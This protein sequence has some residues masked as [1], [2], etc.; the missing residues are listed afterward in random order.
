MKYVSFEM[1]ASSSFGVLQGDRVVAVASPFQ[2]L[3]EELAGTRGYPLSMVRLRAPLPQPGKI[4]CM[5][6]NYVEHA[7]EQGVEPPKSP[8]IFAKYPTA[9]I[10][11]G[12]P[13]VL[14]S[15][16]QKVDY[17]AE[18]AVVIG[19]RGKKIAESHALDHVL[20]YTI[21]N[22][23]S[24]RD[25]QFTDGQ[26]VR[27]KSCDTFAPLG[28]WIVGK[29]EIPDPHRLDIELRVNGDLRQA[30]NTR[31]QIFKIPFL[32]SYLSQA[33]TLE[34]GDILSTGTPS[35]VGVF[36]DPP[37]FLKPGDVVEITIEAIGTLQNPVV[38]EER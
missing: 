4:M 8:V 31:H 12:D 3:E 1:N 23:V 36:R 19:R 30:S 29:E 16:S 15:I 9:V 32:I 35:G 27:G 21:L 22:D 33:M 24:A 25:L 2:V 38:G 34:P 6:R 17:E 26:W 11:P 10:G 20:G 5:G 37:V 28:P 14:P 13:I 7:R 18:L